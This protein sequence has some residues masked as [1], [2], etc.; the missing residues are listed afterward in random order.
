MENIYTNCNIITRSEIFH[1]T[2]IVEDGLIKE[3]DN[4]IFHGKGAIDL[5]GDMMLPGLIEM[6]TDNLEKNIQPRPGVIWPSIMA[7]A[8]AHDAQIAGAGITTVY[9]AVAIGGLRESSLRDQILSE[10]IDAL[11]RGNSLGIFRA[12]H[13]IH[14]RCEISDAR[15]KDNLELH[16]SCAKVRLISIMDHTPGQRQWSDLGKWRQYHREKRWT[17]KEAEAICEDLLGRQKLY[18]EKHRKAAIAY[19]HE[20]NLPLASHDDTTVGDAESAAKDNMR[21]AEFP[22]TLEAADKAKELGM[23]T[24]MGAPNAIRGISHSGNISAETL[25]REN[26]LDGLSSDYVPNSLLH[27]AFHLADSLSIPLNK[28]VAMVSANIADMVGLTDRG[29]IAPGKKADMLQVTRIDNLPII[30]KVWRRGVV[31]A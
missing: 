16:G 18:A 26:L 8:I 24:I 6:H 11:C 20:R 21:I 5:A 29:E 12:E 31:V 13:F 9:D 28:S 19:A 1:G 27:S 4:S 7:S 25:A 22:T 15:M 17:D 23:M 2:V 30:R 10:S 14:L 3:M